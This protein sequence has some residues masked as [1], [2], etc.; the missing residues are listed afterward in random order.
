MEKVYVL[1][2]EKA[3]CCIWNELEVVDDCLELHSEIYEDDFDSEK[4]YYLSKENTEYL[5]K[6]IPLESLIEI[7]KKY[8]TIHPLV[9]IIDAIGIEYKYDSY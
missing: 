7:G 4:H 6:L 1:L 3:G 9:D 8:G 2:N 5:L